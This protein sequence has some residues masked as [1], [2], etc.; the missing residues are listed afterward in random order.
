MVGLA[1]Q[2]VQ[3]VVSLSFLALG[4]FTV[5][6]WLRH[7]GRSRGYLAL[8]LATLGLTSVLGQLN[9]LT[10]YRLSVLGGLT[11]SSSWRPAIPCSSSATASSP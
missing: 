7:Q 10:G 5:V 9:A 3:A 6:D 8:A 11:L 4:V 1:L 2:M